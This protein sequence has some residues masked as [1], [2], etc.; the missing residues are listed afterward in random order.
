MQ[1]GL[2]E[3]VRECDRVKVGTAVHVNDT[4]KVQV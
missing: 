2:A 1:E 4:E 3:V